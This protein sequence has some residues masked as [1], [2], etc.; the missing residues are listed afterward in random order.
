VIRT[1]RDGSLYQTDN[2][3]LILDC[4]TVA[5][6]D[7]AALDRAILDIPGVVGTGLFLGMAETVLIQHEDGS[8]EI[9]H[10]AP[11]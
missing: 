10:P 11:R 4:H 6:T 5:I 7:P 9:R 3:N 8:V 2:G 1:D